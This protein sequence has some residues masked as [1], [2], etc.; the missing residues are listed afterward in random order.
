MFTYTNGL[1]II[2]LQLYI[3]IYGQKW[4]DQMWH[5]QGLNQTRPPPPPQTTVITIPQTISIVP[6]IYYII[7]IIDM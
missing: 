5:G 6:I 2:D 1:T 4:H 3:Y 7:Y